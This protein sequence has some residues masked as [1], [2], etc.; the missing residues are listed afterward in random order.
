MTSHR[1]GRPHWCCQVCHQP[2][3]CLPARRDLRRA[4][5]NGKPGEVRRA[6]DAARQDAESDFEVLGILAEQGDLH[7]RFLGWLTPNRRRRSI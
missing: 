5:G 4:A 1:P 3:P 2:W 7:D 6:L